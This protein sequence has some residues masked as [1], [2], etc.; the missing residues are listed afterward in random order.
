MCGKFWGERRGEPDRKGTNISLQNQR[1]DTRYTDGTDWVSITFLFGCKRIKLKESAHTEK[2]WI[3][4]GK[5]RTRQAR[6]KN[7]F[8]KEERE[9][10]C[11]IC[12]K[13]LING[14][15]MII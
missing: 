12:I 6:K 13:L 2:R 4:N 5:E 1:Y 14:N 8:D 9:R 7:E 15:T 10:M 11:V 3:K